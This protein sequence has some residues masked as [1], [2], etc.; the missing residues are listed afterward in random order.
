VFDLVVVVDVVH[1]VAPTLRDQVLGDVTTLT[2]SGGA[3]VIKEW[4]PTRTVSHWACWA[5]D[6]FITGDHIQHVKPQHLHEQ[7]QQRSPDELVAIT[8][9]PPRRNNYLL[10]YRRA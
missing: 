8:R 2:R 1:H 10:A 3:Y 5:A 4:E 9:I 6:R 7:V